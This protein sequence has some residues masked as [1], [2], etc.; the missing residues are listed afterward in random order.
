MSSDFHLLFRY[1]HN[2]Y[3]FSA[4]RET[5]IKTAVYILG[6]WKNRKSILQVKVLP[7]AWFAHASGYIWPSIHVARARY[8]EK[9]KINISTRKR[10]NTR[11]ILLTMTSATCWGL[12]WRTTNEQRLRKPRPS[13]GW[14]ILFTHVPCTQ[15]E[16]KNKF[17]GSKVNV[18]LE[19]FCIQFMWQKRQHFPCDSNS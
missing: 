13:D 10:F 18:P 19:R 16:C 7:V 8:F 12:D 15:F 3:I 2:I 11:S 14:I 6:V 5:Y 1:L 17:I 9:F 4:A